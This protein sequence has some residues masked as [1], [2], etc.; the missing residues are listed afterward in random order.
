MTAHLPL[1]L[2]SEQVAAVTGYASAAAFLRDRTRLE[3]TTLFPLPMPTRL[4]RNLRWKGDE[5]LAWVARQGLPAQAGIPIEA[6][7][8][9]KVV[10]LDM[11]RTA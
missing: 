4:T 7:M 10:M 6:I 2:T 5:V 8:T 3:T 9:G 1:Y 11:A